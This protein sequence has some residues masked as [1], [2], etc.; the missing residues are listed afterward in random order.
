M[1][2]IF[3]I[4][5]SNAQRCQAASESHP[6]RAHEQPILMRIVNGDEKWNL[7]K[8]YNFVFFLNL[9]VFGEK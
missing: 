4:Q 6:S 1:I 3:F 8:K 2:D 9:C 7:L 5:N